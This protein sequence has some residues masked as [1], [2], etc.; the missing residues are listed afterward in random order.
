MLHSL[1]RRTFLK[2]L[3]ALAGAGALPAWAHA[4]GA[5]ASQWR[6]WSGNQSAQP[7]HLAYPSDE[8][9]LARLLARSEG[10][11]R[12]LGGSHSF[13]ALVP[14]DGTLISLEAFTGLRAHSETSLRF[15]AGTRIAQAGQQ[16]WQQGF[17]LLNEPDI[18]LQ[19]LAGAIATAT[20]GTGL[21]LPSL[22]GQVQGLTLMDMSGQ[23][24]TLDARHGDR[25][26]AACCALGALGIVTDIT[27]RA[28]P[29]YRLEEHSWT[30]PLEEALEFVDKEK[31]NFRNIEMFAFPL[32]GA[33]ILKTMTLTDDPDD[34]NLEPEDSNDLLETVSELSRRAG[35]LTSTLQKLV[36]L[37]VRETRRRGPAH[38]IYPNRRTV[39][40]NEMEY[41]VPAER[42]LECLRAVCETIRD[43]DVNVF[44]PIEFR[45]TASDDT[46][47]S[48]FSGR[49]GASISVHQYFKQDYRPLFKLTEPVLRAHQGRPHWGKLHSLGGQ[50]L[51]GLYPRFDDFLAIRRRFDP[52]GR[53]L[54][55]HL[56]RLFSDP[57]VAA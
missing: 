6:N 24:H 52:Q 11:V 30:M 51:R 40:F 44:F 22:S 48:M 10:T 41:T 54:N 27:L 57:E 23:L 28:P 8:A 35:W 15:G 21:G 31:E 2:T 18:N 47:L 3:A 43:H 42:G 39:L 33:A 14:T 12:A 4:A 16:A 9:A 49:A 5:A 32:G 38:R 26:Q 37:F 17:S 53:L 13:S 7:R 1:P 19:S 29:A 25:F 20:H 55:A 36:T 50:Q 34:L 46:L 45:Y 56:R